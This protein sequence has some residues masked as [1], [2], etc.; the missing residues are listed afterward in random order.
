MERNDGKIHAVFFK[1]RKK[2]KKRMTTTNKIHIYK[3][4]FSLVN[5]IQLIEIL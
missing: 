2:K 3:I 5:L 4:F 1:K